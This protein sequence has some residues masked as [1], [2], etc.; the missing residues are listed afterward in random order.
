MRNI[1]GK[2]IIWRM[3][4]IMQN[5]MTIGKA[6]TQSTTTSPEERKATYLESWSFV[7][8]RVAV[9]PRF[10][11]LFLHL[12]LLLCRAAGMIRYVAYAS[13]ISLPWFSVCVTCFVHAERH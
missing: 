12:R 6:H 10:C 11:V 1:K 9:V 13:R 2:A 3:L 5:H 4:N 8:V 7:L